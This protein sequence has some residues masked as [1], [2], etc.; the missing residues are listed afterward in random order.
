MSK[1]PSND[2]ARRKFL[3]AAAGV[4]IAMATSGV[5]A[6]SAAP[7]A[8]VRRK[9][10]GDFDYDVIVV[11]GGFAGATAA[12]ELG[13]EGYRTLLVEGRSRLGGR[14]FTSKFLGQE[15]EFGG[16]WI[17]WLQP[18]VWAEIRRYGL[19]VI[20]DPLT[21]L[22]RTAVMFNDGS[23]TNLKPE[24]FINNSRIGFEKF[25]HDA[26]DLFPRP[27]EPFLNKQ[28]VL[29][30]DKLSARDRINELKGLTPVQ[31]VQLNSYL[32]LYGGGKTTEYGL[33]QFLKLF[34]CGGWNYDA[35]MDTETHYRISGGGTI[36]LIN[37]MVK[38][39]GAEVSLSTPVSRITQTAQ[40]ASI[41]TEDGDTITAAAIVLTA[42]LNTYKD[43]EFSPALSP[44]K[45]ALAKEGDLSQ[46][47]K[48]YVHVK[49]NL[50]RVFAFADEEQ[51]LNWVQTHDSNDQLGTILSITIAR[52]STIDVNN[53]E[54]VA[55]ET[56]KLYPGV[57]V[58]ASTAYD[59]YNDPF[60]KGAW[61]AYKVG[62]FSHLKDMQQP[63]GRLFFAGASTANGWH[64]NIDGAVESGL[65]A[66]HEV[67]SFLG[68]KV[69]VNCQKL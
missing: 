42:P 58:Q 61:P 7:S 68:K 24:E 46:G 40:G 35:F 69:V 41:T 19:G 21:D 14:T 65:R 23:V 48:L 52:R 64:E 6:A 55:R 16:A 62:Q 30:L 43:I 45:Q 3:S 17:H 15:I 2:L 59:W 28:R 63:E 54:V 44:V 36:G 34:A 51:P 20:E 50:G 57:E 49:Q 47:C 56:R 18:H 22:D 27:Y 5:M 29:E 33:P 12:R 26:R 1:P 31:R 25:C 8:P 38:D 4:S 37:A 10:T 67:K 66:G 53:A 32:A 9:K 60:S 13:K 39:S 11:G